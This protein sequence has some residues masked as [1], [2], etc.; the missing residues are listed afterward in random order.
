MCL[1]W[2]RREH[3]LKKV[4]IGAKIEHDAHLKTKR[5]KC[6]TGK[7]EVTPARVI[8]I[9]AQVPTASGQA[10][11]RLE[12]TPSP[13]ACAVMEDSPQFQPL[14]PLW[15]NSTASSKRPVTNPCNCPR[16]RQHRGFARAQGNAAESDDDEAAT[17]PALLPQ[18]ANFACA[19][20]HA[21]YHTPAS[22]PSVQSSVSTPSNHHVPE[23]LNSG[24]MVHPQVYV[25][26]RSLPHL[27]FPIVDYS[28]NRSSG[29]P[30]W[31][32]FYVAIVPNCATLNDLRT[33]LSPKG[34]G[35]F[36]SA[37]SLDNGQNVEISIFA[38]VTELRCN[39]IQLEVR[40]NETKTRHA[41]KKPEKGKGKD[42]TMPVSFGFPPCWVGAAPYARQKGERKKESKARKTSW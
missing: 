32:H 23:N 40:D 14:S 22:G 12:K 21:E 5:N 11:E 9:R 39:T 34:S 10:V 15:G 38:D 19:Y 18:T 13:S 28:T 31:P 20:D 6:K 42:K 27:S 4:Y 36:L 3:S 16:C 7:K 29:A 26:P 25:Y 17:E 8:N 2:S 30:A 35:T 41:E 37:R 1:F 33:T 24:F